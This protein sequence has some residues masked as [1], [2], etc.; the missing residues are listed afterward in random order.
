MRFFPEPFKLTD[1]V[2]TILRDLIHERTGLYYEIDKRDMLAEKLTPRVLERGLNSFLDY[3][4]LLKY[5]PVAEEEWQ[6]CIDILSVQET[7][8]W[9]E[10]DPLKALVDVILPQFLAARRLRGSAGGAGEMNS[11]PLRIWSAACATGEEPISIA[12][13]LNEAG[14]FDRLNIEIYASDAAPSAISKARSGLYRARSFRNFSP[15]LQQKYFTREEKGWRISR[16][17]HDRIQWRTA[18]LMD[19]SAVEYLTHCHIIFCRN[20]FIYF[21]QHAIR[22]VAERFF[23][24]MPTPGYLFLGASESLLKI[25][26]GFELK[27]INEAFVYVKNSRK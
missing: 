27:Q 10:S 23:V 16:S 7:F 4:Y 1:S 22:E 19:K 26:T 20:V 12:I 15:T 14:W 17:I 2:F 6:A 11:Q 18:N 13:A 8:F 24:G 21:S 25:S 9:R 3:Y 5:D